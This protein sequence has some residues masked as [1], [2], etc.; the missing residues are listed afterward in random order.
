VDKDHDIFLEE[1]EPPAQSQKILSADDKW[2]IIMS[3]GLSVKRLL[4]PTSFRLISPGIKCYCEKSPE[5]ANWVQDVDMSAMPR[6][7][8]KADP[9]NL[10][11]H[12]GTEPW[13][14][15]LLPRT[16]SMLEGFNAKAS[17]YAIFDDLR[18]ECKLLPTSN[19]S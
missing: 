7:S 14:S 9:T 1:G 10:G 13:E 8:E 16:L 19:S 18:M 17:K 6:T 12:Y 5:L 11:K 2:L 15:C 3:A 4:N